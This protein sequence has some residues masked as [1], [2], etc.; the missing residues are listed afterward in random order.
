MVAVKPKS[1]M[2]VLLIFDA[3]HPPQFL[4]SKC[5]SRGPVNQTPRSD[6]LTTL[7]SL[8]PRAE[9]F[10]TG[11]SLRPALQVE[12]LHSERYVGDCSVS[13]VGLHTY[14]KWHCKFCFHQ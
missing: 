1:E 3:A 5:T 14:C 7:V 10:Q 8:M 4:I 6:F 11:V 12:M 2:Y 13:S 9:M